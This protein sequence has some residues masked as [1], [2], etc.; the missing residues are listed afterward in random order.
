MIGETVLAV[1]FMVAGV[2]HFVIRRSISRSC[3]PIYL[4]HGCSS[5]SV[6][7]QRYWVALV[8]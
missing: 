5:A 4:R 3:R 1:L 6:E 2:L 7:P 8:L